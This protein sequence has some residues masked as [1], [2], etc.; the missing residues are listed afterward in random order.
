[1][2]RSP[3]AVVAAAWAVAGAVLGALSVAD[4]TDSGRLPMIVAA[5]IGVAAAA[6]AAVLLHRG[7]SR[8]AGALL[9]LSAVTPTGFAYLPN[10]AAVLGG[11]ALLMWPHQQ[12]SV[13]P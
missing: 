12:R 6:A 10:L 9:V 13:A 8:A 4:A 1:M 2:T 11:L 5:V 3:A 7:H